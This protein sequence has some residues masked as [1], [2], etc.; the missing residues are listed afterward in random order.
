MYL[1]NCGLSEPVLPLIFYCWLGCHLGTE[2]VKASC[3]ES[4][5]N[6]EGLC[7]RGN[8]NIL[9]TMCCVSEVKSTGSVVSLCTSVQILALPLTAA[10]SLATL[11]APVSENQYLS[12]TIL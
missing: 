9:G 12:P 1:A 7:F 5:V 11:G 4:C 6:E 10:R 3:L 8:I 2:M